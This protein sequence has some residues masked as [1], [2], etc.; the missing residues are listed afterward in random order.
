MVR[1]VRLALRLPSR[2]NEQG[3]R[4]GAHTGE[5]RSWGRVLIGTFPTFVLL[6]G[7]LYAAYG[8]ESASIPVAR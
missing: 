8:T 5:T 4:H 3:E 7:S 1:R 2:S 6:Q